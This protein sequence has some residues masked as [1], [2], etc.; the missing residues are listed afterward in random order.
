MK[1]FFYVTSNKPYF[2]AEVMNVEASTPQEAYK[3]ACQAC[4]TLDQNKTPFDVSL[5]RAG[6][7][8]VF[9]NADV[10]VWWFAGKKVN[11]IYYG[12]DHQHFQDRE[13]AAK[14]YGYCV[15]HSLE[16]CGRFEDA[17]LLKELI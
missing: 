12:S 7:V 4:E 14:R 9:K 17:V 6:L 3:K 1:Y 5:I 16:C 8:T 2:V 15:L 11:Y 10:P 13:E